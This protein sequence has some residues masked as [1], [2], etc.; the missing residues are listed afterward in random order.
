MNL[1][2]RLEVMRSLV[3]LLLWVSGELISVVL[4]VHMLSKFMF[5]SKLGINMPCLSFFMASS[6]NFLRLG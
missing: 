4:G 6:D 1:A 2:A 5:K 3:D